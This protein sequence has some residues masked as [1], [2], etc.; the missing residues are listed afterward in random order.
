M[1]ET[2][3]LIAGDAVEQWA[4]LES[5]IAENT[6]TLARPPSSNRLLRWLR[7]D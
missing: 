2:G 1:S 3:S 6:S 4:D 7:E 5:G